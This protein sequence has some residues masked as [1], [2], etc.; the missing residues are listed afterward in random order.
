LVFALGAAI[1]IERYAY[2]TLAKQKNR[3]MW[4]K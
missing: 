2:L 4:N 3:S 1:A